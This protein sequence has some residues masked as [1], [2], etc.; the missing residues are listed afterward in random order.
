MT[1]LDIQIVKML[2]ALGHKQQS[3]AAL[4]DVNQGRIAEISCG[5][6]D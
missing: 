2:L 4:F 6:K 5:M 3:I 1:E